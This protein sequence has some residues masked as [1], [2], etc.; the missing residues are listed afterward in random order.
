MIRDKA[1]INEVL[2]SF[3]LPLS[4]LIIRALMCK[5]DQCP[6]FEVKNQEQIHTLF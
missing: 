3:I 5:Y 1:G 6:Q 2:Y 4:M